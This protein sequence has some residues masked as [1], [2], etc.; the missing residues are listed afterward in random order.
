MVQQAGRH[1]VRPV[2][3]NAIPYA[4]MSAPVAVQGRRGARTGGRRGRGSR[5]AR[6]AALAGPLLRDAH[7]RGQ[8]VV[9]ADPCGVQQAPPRVPA[10][11]V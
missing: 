3:I 8:R 11:A 2:V 10:L 4:L 7:Q 1:M 9:R 5:R 6:A